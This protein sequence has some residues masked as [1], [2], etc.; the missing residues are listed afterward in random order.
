MTSDDRT[1]LKKQNSTF[2][3]GDKAQ[4]SEARAKLQRGIKAAK[5]LEKKVEE[6]LT[7]NS[8]CLVWQGL[9][10]ITNYRGSTSVDTSLAE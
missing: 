9:Q 3:L 10:S 4:C 6:H 7:N 8:P 1:H 5:R 2:K